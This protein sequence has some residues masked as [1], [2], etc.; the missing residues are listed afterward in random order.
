MSKTSARRANTSSHTGHVNREH[1][2]TSQADDICHEEEAQLATQFL[3]FPKLP[4]EL[5]AEIWKQHFSNYELPPRIMA[6]RLHSLKSRIVPPENPFC[7]E[8]CGKFWSPT[9]APIPE[10][11]LVNREST[12]EFK[13]L[14][15]GVYERA[16]YEKCFAPTIFPSRASTGVPGTISFDYARDIAL[17]SDVRGPP[18]AETRML[19][20]LG[21][22]DIRKIRN[23]AIS[24]WNN[25]GHRD[26]TQNF[27]Y[28]C[29][30]LPRFLALERIYLLP[31]EGDGFYD[32]ETSEGLVAGSVL[33]NFDKAKNR[34]LERIRYL[35][36]D[37]HNIQYLQSLSV[38]TTVPEISF[39]SLPG[40]N[41]RQR[42]RDRQAS[43][44]L[45]RERDEEK[46]QRREITARER[47]LLTKRLI[48]SC[49]T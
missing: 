21:M 29:F 32:L 28:F 11:A 13:R 47:E 5:R 22:E 35:R 48:R 19:E 45:E 49:R 9:I 37:A 16:P 33:N 43:E 41:K 12:A 26:F 17:L 44:K 30:L 34:L 24:G 46:S 42:A 7:P 31:E 25:P 2:Q 39:L 38:L 14:N 40:F 1:E 6:I 8:L 15:D 20:I 36:D 3:C 18:H 10:F 4:G 23:V 27:V